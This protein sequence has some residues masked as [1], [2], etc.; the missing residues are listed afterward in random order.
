MFLSR[1]CAWLTVASV[2]P[3]FFSRL[4]CGLLVV[5]KS[6]SCSHFASFPQTLS[7]GPLVRFSH[8]L[9]RGPL[10]VE[11]FVRSVQLLR[12]DFF[13]RLIFSLTIF[14]PSC[15]SINSYF[16]SH[17]PRPNDNWVLCPI[18]NSLTSLITS[19]GLT[20][21]KGLFLI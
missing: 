17:R 14:Y 20:V 7:R 5:L 8:A 2:L 19:A 4:S 6:S 13:M 15:I 3:C 21:H 18:R 16:K 9:S 11:I 12:V 1:F 10:V